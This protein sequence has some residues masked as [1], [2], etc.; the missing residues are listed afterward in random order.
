MAHDRRLDRGP[1]SPQQPDDFGATRVIAQR[2]IRQA[3]YLA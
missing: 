2:A 1:M 3:A